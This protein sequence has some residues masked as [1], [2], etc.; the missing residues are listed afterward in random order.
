M[1]WSSQ[2]RNNNNVDDSTEPPVKSKLKELIR[3]FAT[4]TTI[5]GLAKAM[6]A[7]LIFPRILGIMGTLAGLATGLYL[8]ISILIVYFRYETVTKLEKCNEC[9]PE[10]PDV[11]VCNLN[12]L[13]TLVDIGALHYQDYLGYVYWQ[14]NNAN[15]DHEQEGYAKYLYSPLAYMKNVDF[16]FIVNRIT[17]NTFVHDCTW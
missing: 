5:K 8:L 3:T 15:L 11:T 1:D 12:V 10:F 17:M 2:E 16:E 4:N 6:R 13:G 14:S 9:K 7:T